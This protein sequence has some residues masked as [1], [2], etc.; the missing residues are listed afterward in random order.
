MKCLK[1]AGKKVAKH[2]RYRLSIFFQFA[3]TAEEF[4]KKYKDH[5]KI[6][7]SPGLLFLIFI[8]KND[9]RIFFDMENLKFLLITFWRLVILAVMAFLLLT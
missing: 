4:T 7:N 3:L 9:F 1:Q 5:H 6:L 8:I 2:G